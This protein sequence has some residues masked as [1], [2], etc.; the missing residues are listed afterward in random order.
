[1]IT[2][3]ITITAISAA[4]E[5]DWGARPSP[6]ESRVVDAATRQ[7]LTRISKKWAASI[8]QVLASNRGEIQFGELSRRLSGISNKMLWSTLRDLTR[9]GLVARREEGHP[10]QV[11]YRLSERGESLLCALDPLRQWVATNVVAHMLETDSGPDARC[12]ET[13]PAGATSPDTLSQI[14]DQ[15]GN[16]NAPS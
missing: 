13:T 5:V 16:C 4:G 11:H 12:D 8:L 3:S 9:D 14:A 15:N 10:R 7:L 6:S 1:M 2:G